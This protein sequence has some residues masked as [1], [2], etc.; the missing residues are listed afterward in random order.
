MV[1]VFF[2][3]LLNRS[4]LKDYLKFLKNI[5]IIKPI[6]NSKPAKANKKN[7]VEVKIKSSLIVPTI[8]T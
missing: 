7:D 2:E 1:V 5:T 3:K 8:E 4:K 6:Q